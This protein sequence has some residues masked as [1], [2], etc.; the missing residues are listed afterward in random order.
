MDID[1]T[2]VQ[3]AMTWMAPLRKPGICQVNDRVE[4]LSLLFSKLLVFQFCN[5]VVFSRSIGNSKAARDRKGWF[6]C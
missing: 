6:L 4:H 1:L 5:T 3:N 2:K